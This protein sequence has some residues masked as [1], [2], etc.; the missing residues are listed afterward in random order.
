MKRILSKFLSK[1]KLTKLAVIYNLIRHAPYDYNRMFMH[2]RTLGN[3]K[4]RLLGEIIQ[5]YHSIEKGLTMP[6]RRLGFGQESL[7]RLVKN[8]KKYSDS[9]YSE[10]NQVNHA[11]SVVNEYINLHANEKY[12]LETKTY[13]LLK[14]I[15]DK[16]SI[17]S[18]K[19][20]ISITAKEYFEFNKSSFDLFSK[21]RHSLR[22]FSDKEVDI[23]TI[24][25]AIDLAKNAPSACNRQSSRVHVYADRDEIQKILKIQGGNRGFGHLTNKL[26]IVTSD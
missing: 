15:S 26:I 24:T 4:N 16:R 5:G 13:E 22:N 9:D 2:N 10:S 7:T 23:T 21:S 11:I 20:Q 8:I 12:E 18:S 1:K 3:S 25:K 6:N 19:S 14:N 17:Q